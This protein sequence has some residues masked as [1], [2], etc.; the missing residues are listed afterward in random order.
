VTG[1]ST[2]RISGG[3]TG[4]TEVERAGSAAEIFS[5]TQAGSITDGFY[6]WQ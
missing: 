2:I 5:G 6:S 3:V 1:G 4:S